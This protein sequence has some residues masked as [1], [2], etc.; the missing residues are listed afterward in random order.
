MFL[1]RHEMEH[2]GTLLLVMLLQQWDI[3][4]AALGE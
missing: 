1:K 2:N 3:P 4:A